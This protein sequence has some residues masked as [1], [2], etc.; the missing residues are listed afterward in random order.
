MYSTLVPRSQSVELCIDSGMKHET[1]IWRLE[2]GKHMH[3]S[4]LLLF[5]LMREENVKSW[6]DARRRVHVW[7]GLCPGE[8]TGRSHGV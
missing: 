3:S 5:Y 7:A 1:M 8:E 6:P 2:A 4:R